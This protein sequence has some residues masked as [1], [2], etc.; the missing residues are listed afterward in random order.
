MLKFESIENDDIFTKDFR[1]FKKNNTITF[2]RGDKKT[3]VIYGPNGTGK[4]SLIKVLS[5]EKGTKASFELDGTKYTHSQEV[6]HVINDQNYRNII[7]GEAK[8]FLLGDNIKREFELHK[9]L[10]DERVTIIEKINK[11][12]KSAYN[13]SSINSALFSMINDK[14]IVDIL[15]D[16]INN[17]S[18]GKKHENEFI[19]N[20]FASISPTHQDIGDDEQAKLKFLKSDYANN[21][22]IIRQIEELEKQVVPTN[23]Q[24]QEVEENSEAIRI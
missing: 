6:F 21:D 1:E 13:I 19:F 7:V 22:F 14:E 15:K 11:N 23:S 16:I 20:K 8:D 4:T 24:I 10:N 17:K 2:P 5:D 12:L 3:I 18:K 9:Y